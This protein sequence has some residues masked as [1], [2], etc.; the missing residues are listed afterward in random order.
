MASSAAVRM[1]RKT[2]KPRLIAFRIMSI[3]SVARFGH[4]ANNNNP[5][6]LVRRNT[7]AIQIEA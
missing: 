6:R 3:M 2:A 1:K 5:T 7:A 4:T